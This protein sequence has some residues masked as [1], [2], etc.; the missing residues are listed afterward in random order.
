[1]CIVTGHVVEYSKAESVYQ[2]CRRGNGTGINVP[3]SHFMIAIYQRSQRKFS[4]FHDQGGFRHAYYW[5][6]GEHFA[7][8]TS[9]SWLISILRSK[10]AVQTGF[11]R[12][13]IALY[14]TYQYMLAPHT[15][16]EDVYQI[17]A[18]RIR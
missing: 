4:I 13:A 11:S 10:K 3:D 8:L 6:R 18:A 5:Q 9:L 14:L 12:Q 17:Q 15:M 7:L 1:M 2:K 16:F